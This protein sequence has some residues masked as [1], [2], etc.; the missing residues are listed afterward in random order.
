MRS[1]TSYTL[2]AFFLKPIWREIAMISK[3][4]LEGRRITSTV[5]LFTTYL[6]YKSGSN[7]TQQIL[8]IFRDK[9]LLCKT[10]GKSAQS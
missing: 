8:P 5:L 9:E 4:N 10:L 1:R 2:Q 3:G 7:T 6:S